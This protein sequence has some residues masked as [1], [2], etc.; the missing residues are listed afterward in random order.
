MINNNLYRFRKI[1]SNVIRL[2]F[3]KFKI[4][5]SVSSSKTKGVIPNIV[6]QTTKS[7]WIPVRFWLDVKKFRARNPDFT[8]L[9][10]NQPAMATWM[11]ENYKN[12]TILRAFENSELGVMQSDIFKYC[13]AYKNGGISLDSTKYFTKML[14]SMFC[15]NE[16]TMI[17]SQETNPTDDEAIANKLLQLNLSQ[18]L[19]INWCFA[20]VPLNPAIESVIR[21][22]EENYFKNKSAKFKDV[23]YGVW[24]MTG[25]LAF[26]FGLLQYFTET[27]ESTI[28]IKGSDFDE[29]VWPKFK[30]ANLV[31][32][33]S[34][35]YV[36]L[37]NLVLFK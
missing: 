30:N 27:L 8:F 32:I 16:C 25:P 26:N 31:N 21:H 28:S 37:S 2:N 19:I 29:P 1:L 3:I 5:D 36:E 13:Y 23:K 12:T 4:G 10:F 17:L 35:H 34:R 20:S 24:Q 15:I 9:T 11:K 33:F 14:N 6:F 22:I 18:S 7:K